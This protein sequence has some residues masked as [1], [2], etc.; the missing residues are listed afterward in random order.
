MSIEE[1][2][3]AGFLLSSLITQ[4][5]VDKAE[6]DASDAYILRIAPSVNIT[7]HT[8]AR[9]ALMELAYLLVLQRSIFATR[10]G[11]KEK[12]TPQSY[13]ANRWDILSQQAATAAMRLD[14]LAAEYNLKSWY[15]KV[16]DICGIL[17]TTQIL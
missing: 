4:A 12:T 6:R 10:S 11:A 16:C 5:V 13:T 1:Y 3:Q 14:M 2:R 15:D 8:T 17:F 7:N 9:S